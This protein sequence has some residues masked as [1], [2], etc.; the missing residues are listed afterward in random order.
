MVK[1]AG[2]WPDVT[3]QQPAAICR[4][5][6][7][8]VKTGRPLVDAV[9][10][11]RKWPCPSTVRCRNGGETSLLLYLPSPTFVESAWRWS[12]RCIDGGC[13][14]WRHGALAFRREESHG[15]RAGSSAVRCSGWID[16]SYCWLLLLPCI[17]L[18][19]ILV[20]RRTERAHLFRFLY[21]VGF[22]VFCYWYF[23][24]TMIA[25][26]Q[27]IWNEYIF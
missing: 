16:L 20:H 11:S 26:W 27:K 15:P 2:A 17:W 7:R 19:S 3:R 4:S 14:W 5:D 18:P 25:R 9:G 23:L 8:R 1:L 21:S 6:R 12:R 24:P 22:S 10:I 13:S